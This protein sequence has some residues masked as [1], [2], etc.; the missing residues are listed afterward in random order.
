MDPSYST[1]VF[2]S[3]TV[4]VV[5]YNY[6]H[7]AEMVMYTVYHTFNGANHLQC[8]TSFQFLMCVYCFFALCSVRSI[9]RFRHDTWTM[10]GF[11][12]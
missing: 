11:A 3:C 12:Q 6:V 5:I 10:R 4:S 7:V 1:S 2:L 9:V 8:G